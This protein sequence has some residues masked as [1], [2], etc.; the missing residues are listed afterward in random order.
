MKQS[1]EDLRRAIENLINVKL[2]DALRPDGLARL[3]AHRTSGVA[4]FD[5]R[6]AGRQLE[7]LLSRALA[8]AETKR[9][10]NRDGLDR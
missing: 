2:H 1:G 9:D 3:V 4:S 10:R 8:S 5:I 7:Q 6:N